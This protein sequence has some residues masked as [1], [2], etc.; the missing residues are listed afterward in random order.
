L[1]RKVTFDHK[2]DIKELSLGSR[3]SLAL[4]TGGHIYTWGYSGALGLPGVD[5]STGTPSLIAPE[6]FNNNQIVSIGAGRDFSA[7]L[8]SEG[9]FYVW[10]NGL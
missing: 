1:P 10:G 2:A 5:K 8:D 7:A 4:T 6:V 3:H 9:K